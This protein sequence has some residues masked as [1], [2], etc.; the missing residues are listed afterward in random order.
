[1]LGP[2]DKAK[3]D[4]AFEN[5]LSNQWVEYSPGRFIGVNIN[6]LQ[7]LIVEQTAGLY[8]EGILMQGQL[9]LVTE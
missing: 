4:Y 2:E 8:A 5:E 6:G 9:R 3:L 1:M 7:N